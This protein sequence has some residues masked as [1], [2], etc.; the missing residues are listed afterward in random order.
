MGAEPRSGGKMPTEGK[1][2]LPKILREVGYCGRIY[3]H[4][5]CRAG[6]CCGGRAARLFAWPAQQEGRLARRIAARCLLL[7]GAEG[8]GR[9]V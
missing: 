3:T 5:R 8:A 2:V 7:R 1:E 6:G 9:G 4:Y